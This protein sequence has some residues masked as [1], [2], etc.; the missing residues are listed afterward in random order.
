MLSIHM[1]RQSKSEKGPETSGGMAASTQAR[2][3]RTISR[4]R[5]LDRCGVEPLCKVTVLQAPA[6]YGKTECLTQWRATLHFRGIR[7]ALVRL[8]RADDDLQQFL[9]AM[10]AALGRLG[11]DASELPPADSR[12]RETFCQSTFSLIANVLGASKRPA[13][14]LLD[15]VH[16]IGSDEARRTVELLFRST[17]DHVRFVLATRSKPML[18]LARLAAAGQLARISGQSLLFTPEET[19]FGLRG[20]A[21]HDAAVRI[22]ALT[23]GWPALIDLIVSEGDVQGVLSDLRRGYVPRA[24]AEFFQRIVSNIA[25]PAARNCVTVGAI[26]ERFDPVLAGQMLGRD[27]VEA[28]L[29][30]ALQ[31]GMPLLVA[32]DAKT[33]TYPP[34]L[35]LWLL[36]KLAAESTT[37]G[38]L[39][40]LACHL[41]TDVLRRQLTNIV[42]QIDECAASALPAQPAQ[43]EAAAEDAEHVALSPRERDVLDLIARGM[44]RREIAE[45]LKISESSVKCH[46]GTLF[47]KLRVARRSDAI[48]QGK[49][50]GLL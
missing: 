46:Q 17:P 29:D 38:N 23:S 36:S 44:S 47:R 32:D 26:S 8:E 28:L 39:D 22:Q 42:T 25:P 41:D 43:E 31:S 49:R 11:L 21:S 48:Q 7:S 9:T 4:L 16:W 3:L 6:G 30:A 13:V 20:R 14:I 33:L 10:R 27:D 40:Q 19:H 18:S 2:A 37:L 15:D 50:L 5:L 45:F 34:A 12:D 24:A 35:R 1:V